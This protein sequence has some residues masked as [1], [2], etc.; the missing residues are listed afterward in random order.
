MSNSDGNENIQL[1]PQDASR[2]RWGKNKHKGV[3]LLSKKM[4]TF[5]ISPNHF[6][7]AYTASETIMAKIVKTLPA[8]LR[9]K[10]KTNP[11]HFFFKFVLH[12]LNLQ[13]TNKQK[14]RTHTHK[15]KVHKFQ[16]CK[17]AF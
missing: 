11:L 15:K 14:K 12:R 3:T 9:Y 1:Q 13:K 7:L 16:I 4:Q 17:K 6:F 10:L 2:M 5:L 8:F